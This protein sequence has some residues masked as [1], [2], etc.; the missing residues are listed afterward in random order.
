MDENAILA[1]QVLSTHS[2]VKSRGFVARHPDV[3]NAYDGVSPELRRDETLRIVG[4]RGCG[5]TALG[6]AVLLAIR[7]TYSEVL[8]RSCQQPAQLIL[9]F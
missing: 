7:L 5:K 6:Q 8:F 4:G 1:V 9:S 3:I 2:P